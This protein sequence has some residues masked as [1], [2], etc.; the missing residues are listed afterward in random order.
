MRE[1]A[2]VAVFIFFLVGI[3]TA[4]GNNFGFQPMVNEISLYQNN[5]QAGHNLGQTLQIISINTVKV[6]TAF[7]IEFTADFNRHL[8]PGTNREYYLEIGL[9]KP[10]WQKLSVN[11]QRVHGTFVCEPVNQ[12]GLRWSF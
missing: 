12:F 7:N 11:Y 4:G 6:G 5:S 10:V 3:S 9:V 8:T 2:K 1:F